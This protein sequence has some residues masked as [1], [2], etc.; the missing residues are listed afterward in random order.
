MELE[1]S[2]SAALL[3]LSRLNRD[4]SR[5]QILRDKDRLL[6][7][8]NDINMLLL[9]HE[10]KTK[11]AKTGGASDDD[12][13]EG[14][15]DAMLR[16]RG[17]SLDERDIRELK[18]RRREI[19]GMLREIEHLGRDQRQ[20]SAEQLAAMDREKRLLKAEVLTVL[21]DPAFLFHRIQKVRRQ[22]SEGKGAKPIRYLRR[23][24]DQLGRNGVTDALELIRGLADDEQHPSA[25]QVL[26]VVSR[27]G[28][29][30]F[31]HA[32]L[33]DIERLNDL[34]PEESSRIVREI[35]R[36]VM[37]F[38]EV[39]RDDWSEFFSGKAI[40]ED[41]E[42]MRLT[43]LNPSSP[44]EL[45]VGLLQCPEAELERCRERATRHYG[46]ARAVDVMTE[47]L[48]QSRDPELI[49]RILDIVEE[50]PILRYRFYHVTAK[51]RDL[52][53]ELA[54]RVLARGDLGV[55]DAMAFRA[56]NPAL[57]RRPTSAAQA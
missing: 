6:K 57:S 54:R 2:L 46:S 11:Q 13:A 5:D 15:I 22:V 50:D 27:S 38:Q 20:L 48:R 32:L 36:N 31:L 7:E 9:L 55:E 14:E 53:A 56:A 37:L 23:L 21:E 8:R 16:S 1:R 41:L 33:D 25:E 43:L 3:K 26:A 49:G 24:V 28:L 10:A 30:S 29:G 40:R 35:L 47:V 51:Q 39:P 17:G 45:L 4:L 18:S 44:C 42:W 19:A 12:L 34:F 52:P